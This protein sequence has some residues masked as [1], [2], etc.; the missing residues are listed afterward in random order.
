MA[1]EIQMTD[2]AEWSGNFTSITVFSVSDAFCG[3]V[4][5]KQKARQDL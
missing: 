4:T 2:S 5:G 3:C 1:G